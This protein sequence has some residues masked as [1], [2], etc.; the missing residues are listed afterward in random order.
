MPDFSGLLK[1]PAGESKK[2]K[3]LVFG[4]YQGIIKGH[5]VEA[6]PA[7]KDYSAIIRIQVGLTDWPDSATEEDRQDDST[8]TMKPIDLSKRQMRK[9]FYDTSLFRLDDLIR[10]CGIE[11]NGRAYEEVLPELTGAPLVVTMGTY[12]NDRTNE[13]GNQINGIAG[14]K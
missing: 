9:D 5:S 8:G 2:P 4:D 7:G 1:R 11:P 10:S 6:A 12:H 3:L 14:Q 13:F